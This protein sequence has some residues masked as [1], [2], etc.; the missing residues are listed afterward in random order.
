[1]AATNVLERTWNRRVG[2]W[3]EHVSSTTG[4]Q[5]VLDEVFR[6]ARPRA[7]DVC[8]DLGAG[9]GFLTMALAPEVASVLAVDISPAMTAALDEMVRD[10]GIQNVSS[11]VADLTELTLP[12]DSVDLVVSNYALHHL[13]DADKRALVGRA[14]RWV[15]PGGR[16]VV[17]DMM[18]GRGASRRD[19]QILV[20]KLRA[21]AVKGP[22]GWWRIVKNLARFGFGIGQEHPASPESWV[23]ALEDA[24][25]VDVTFRPVVAEAG[26]V[27][28]I[29]DFGATAA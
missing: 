16:L 15:R 26:V 13:I 21:L 3:H 27:T 28:G 8:V 5:A 14:A 22:G 17:A 12:D 7:S 29:R 9:T 4:F 1:M 11:R 19:R 6:A 20:G 18:F 10:R 23:R 2:R 25:F 24:G